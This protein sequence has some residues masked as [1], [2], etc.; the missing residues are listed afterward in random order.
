MQA[1][2]TTSAAAAAAAEATVLARDADYF[3]GYSLYGPVAIGDESQGFDAN[4]R[5]YKVSGIP[6]IQLIDRKGRIR[7]I[8]IGYDEANEPKLAAEIAR[9]LAEK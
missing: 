2:T 8:M 5:N 9:L 6:Q 4:D 1:A 7:L 3:K